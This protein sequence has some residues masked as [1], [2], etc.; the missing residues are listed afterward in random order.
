MRIDL[1]TTTPCHSPT[2]SGGCIS[3]FLCWLE[4]EHPPLG[5]W[6]AGS[7]RLES[8]L[9]LQ[10]GGSRYPF[11]RLAVHQPRAPCLT[12]APLPSPP[13]GRN[14][15]A[16]RL[17]AGGWRCARGLAAQL[18]TR[19]STGAWP[20]WIFLDWAVPHDGVGPKA[21]HTRAWPL[22]PAC[23]AADHH[24]GTGAR[25]AAGAFGVGAGSGAHGVWGRLGSSCPRQGLFPL[26]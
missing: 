10:L 2:E 1:S 6:L 12:T 7:R 26:A 16:D 22:D 5:G 8:P 13:H 17:A 4:S 21:A 15:L 3:I 19:D 18:R 9:P 20:L 24:A 23:A 14:P 25:I 11:Q